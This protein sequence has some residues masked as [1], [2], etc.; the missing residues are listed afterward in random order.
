MGAP[1][2]LRVLL[3]GRHWLQYETF[4]RRFEAAAQDLALREGDLRLGRLTVGERQYHRWVYGGLAGHP[5]PDACRVLEHLTGRPVA[6]LFAMTPA[7]SQDPQ[8]AGTP[9]VRTPVIQRPVAVQSDEDV[10]MAAARES[11]DFAAFAEGS[12]VG[13][14]TLDQLRADIE[15]IVLTYPNRPVLP[16]FA[17]V[18]EVRNRAFELLEGHQPPAYTRDLYLTAGL[19][20]GILA[21][22]SLDLGRLPAAETQA[23]TAFLCA[24]LAGHN[25]LRCWVRGMQSLI[26]YWDDRPRDAAALA[27]DGWEYVPEAGTARV[28][29][30]SLEARAQGRLQQ[31]E[32]AQD[33]LRRAEHAREQ[34]RGP[35]EPG[36]MLS[37]PVARQLFYAST[38]D[39]WLGGE[40][41]YQ[42]AEREAAEA[43]RLF[44]DEPPE[45]R[46]LG[47]L[48]LARLDLATARLARADLEGSADQTREVMR[49]AARR[50]T[51]PVTRRLR[52][53]ASRIELPPYGRS[54]AALGIREEILSF[55]TPTPLAG[56]DR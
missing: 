19:L 17:E 36:G 50:R 10:V 16:I 39:L 52:Q 5:R 35:D 27:R 1:N 49:A 42:L 34:V 21:N 2:Q 33:A 11:A 28:R 12:N 29:V 40:Q 13:P 30:A 14:H 32:A 4:R 31:E 53:L 37:F 9:A 45:Q 55:T 18:R 38:A 3:A 54:P 22:A 47:E 56:E 25:G 7:G 26:A 23:R 44:E 15:R 8:P 43:V 48:C 20:C 6:E 24:E 41:R 51:E 46:R